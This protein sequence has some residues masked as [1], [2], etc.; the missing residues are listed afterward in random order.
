M[1][2]NSTIKDNGGDGV[3]FCGSEVVVVDS[4]FSGMDDKAISVGEKTTLHAV[5]NLIATSGIGIASKDLSSTHVYGG[6]FYNNERAL[7]AYRKKPVFGGGTANVMGSLFWRN[8]KDFEVDGVSSIRLNGVGLYKAPAQSGIEI[9][10]LRLGRIESFYENDEN[11]VPSFKGGAGEER[12]VFAK[13]PETGE[14]TILGVTIPNLAK[15]P[16]GM[17]RPLVNGR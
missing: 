9:A 5:N 10:G 12:G 16:V 11:G 1:I 8:K 13:G 3:D 6:A 17:I 15:S 14:L 4:I 7:S 2:R